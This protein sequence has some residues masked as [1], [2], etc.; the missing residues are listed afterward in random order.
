MSRMLSGP[1]RSSTGAGRGSTFSPAGVVA[2]PRGSRRASRRT[3][4][5][6]TGR[7]IPGTRGDLRA[8]GRDVPAAE[9]DIPAA[10]HGCARDDDR[11]ADLLHTPPRTAARR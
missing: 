8:A 3:P 10:V 11:I 7:D 4:L 5:R 9:G 6:A 2:F 1:F